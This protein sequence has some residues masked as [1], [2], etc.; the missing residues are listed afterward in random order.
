M[1]YTNLSFALVRGETHPSVW[2]L[3]QLCRVLRIKYAEAR[4]LVALDQGRAKYG[5]EFWT[6][7]GWKPKNDEFYVLWYFLT[8]EERQSF[9]VQVQ[10]TV[11]GRK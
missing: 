7:F 1:E 3:H 11:Q 2:L 4:R 10:A 6:L 9:L 8:D 5:P